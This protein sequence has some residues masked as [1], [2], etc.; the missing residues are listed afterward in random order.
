MANTEFKALSPPP[1]ALQQG[2]TE[3]LRAVIVDGGLHVSLIRGFE[4]VD[5]WG[6]LLVDL[7]RHAARIF[8]RET[9]ISEDEAISKIDRMYRKEMNRPTDPGTTNSI[10]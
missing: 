4:A 10:Q 7:A 2:G 5:V 9:G 1:T 3:I 8:A 6:I